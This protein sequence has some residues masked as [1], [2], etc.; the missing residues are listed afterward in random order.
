[1]MCERVRSS[2]HKWTQTA[3]G[4]VHVRI[5]APHHHNDD[6]NDD[7]HVN[8]LDQLVS[9]IQQLPTKIEW[10]AESWHYQ[11]PMQ[12]PQPIRQ[13][14]MALYIL[15]LDAINF[16][17]W[18]SHTTSDGYGYEYD[19]LATTLTRIATLDH[20]QQDVDV[21]TVS[22]SFTLSAE[23]LSEMNLLQMEDLFR[24]NHSKNWIPPNMN[25]RV[26]LLNELGQVLLH[27]FNGS[28]MQVIQQADCSASRLVDLIYE[29]FPGFRDMST[30]T[31]NDKHD[32]NNCIYFLK[33]AQIL[34]GDWNASLQLD[35]KD[36]DQLTTFADYRVPQL[37]RHLNVLSYSSALADTVD[38]QRELLRDSDEEISIRAAT[39]AS[40]DLIVQELARRDIGRSWSAVE[41][42]WYLW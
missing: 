24:H 12:W 36:M 16:C 21:R 2:C 31:A 10:D 38:G 22:S 25:Q 19:D 5:C 17:F 40:V 14:R 6:D 33:R 26:L 27:K 1:M 3:R 35:L 15:A 8:A 18:P 37:L 7:T 39:V 28:A 4:Q 29:H 13:E 20:P 30:I 23:S 11:P 9:Q 41:V 32:E 34:V 42:D